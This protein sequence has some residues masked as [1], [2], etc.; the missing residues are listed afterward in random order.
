MWLDDAPSKVRQIILLDPKGVVSGPGHYTAGGDVDGQAAKSEEH[1]AARSD[2]GHF[3]S[4]CVVSDDEDPCT[5]TT[6]LWHILMAD[7]IANG[8]GRNGIDNPNSA[9]VV[10]IL[11]FYSSI[12]ITC[13]V[14]RNLS[15][16]FGV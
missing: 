12:R 16:Y 15:L 10:L 4:F 1:S 7:T 9:E 13:P 6:W 11:G 3:T 5:G 8:P 14:P 2:L